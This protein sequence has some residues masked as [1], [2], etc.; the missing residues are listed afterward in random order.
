MRRGT[1]RLAELQRQFGEML[2][3][4]LDRSSGTLR[5]IPDRYDPALRA[6]VVGDGGARLAVYH[7]QYWFRLFGVLQQAYRLATALLGPWAFNDLAARFLVAHPPSG[8][9]LGRVVDGFE[10]FVAGDAITRSTVPREA[11]I[12]AVRIDDAFRAVFA[13][14]DAAPVVLTPADAARLLGARLRSA[15]AF[16][17]IDETWPLIA[18]RDALP[19]TPSE[20]VVALP[21]P[22]DQGRRT[23]AICRGADGQ[24]V[25]PL[26]AAHAA[27]LRLLEM[28]PLGEAL[29]RLERDLEP[30]VAA[31]VLVEAQRW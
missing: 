4:P 31:G 10:A 14:P 19:I 11:L 15:P 6:A 16:A 12:E 1:A 17:L 20:R 5:A 25:L 7:R 23:W 29:A 27:L 30:A 2:R 26:S 9:D 13:A 22:H 8:H 28:Y 18:L 3:A 21:P 24:R